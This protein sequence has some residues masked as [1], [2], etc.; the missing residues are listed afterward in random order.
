MAL[1][2]PDSPRVGVPHFPE[3][4]ARLGGGRRHV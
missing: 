2:M 1:G 3:R 4:D